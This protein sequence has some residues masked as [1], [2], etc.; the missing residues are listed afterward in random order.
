MIS[1]QEEKTTRGLGR[2]TNKGGNGKSTSKTIPRPSIVKEG[3]E[4]AHVLEVVKRVG[5]IQRK[6]IR[7]GPLNH[8]LLFKFI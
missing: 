3:S 5:G 7:N 4:P 1:A 2:K 8:F 6:K